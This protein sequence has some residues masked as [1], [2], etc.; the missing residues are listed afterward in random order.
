MVVDLNSEFQREKEKRED[1]PLSA[2]LELLFLLSD[3][4][5][6]SLDVFEYRT[7]KEVQ[8]RD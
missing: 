8:S 7:N 1:L 6:I 4:V 3:A 2:L 5:I